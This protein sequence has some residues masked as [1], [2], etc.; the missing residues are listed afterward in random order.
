MFKQGLE[1]IE[2]QD[3]EDHVV[4]RDKHMCVLLPSRFFFFNQNTEKLGEYKKYSEKIIGRTR[5]VL[6][7]GHRDIEINLSENNCANERAH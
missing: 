6:M 4:P 5:L 1:K 7:V 3:I 2:V